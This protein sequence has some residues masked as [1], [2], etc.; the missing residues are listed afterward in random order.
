MSDF[1]VITK[2]IINHTQENFDSGRDNAESL[3]ALNDLDGGS[4]RLTVQVSEAEGASVCDRETR[5]FELDCKGEPAYYLKH[6][7]EYEKDLGKARALLW[8]RC[9]LIVCKM[10]ESQTGFEDAIRNN[11]IELLLVIKKY[12]LDREETRAWMSVVAG[13]RL[14]RCN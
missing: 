1:E 11:P 8:G 5:E 13:A 12:E 3:R 2:H 9:Q 6:T 14:A 7:R 4:W 10:I